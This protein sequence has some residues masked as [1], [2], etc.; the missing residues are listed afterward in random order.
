MQCLSCQ[1]EIPTKLG[2]VS[3]CHHYCSSCFSHII[4]KR[5]RKY[6]KECCPL[7]KGQRILAKDAVSRYFVKN[8]LHVPVT[9]VKKSQKKSD[10]VV[11]SATLDDV[12]VSFLESFLLGK[13]Q[14]TRKDRKN[15]LLLFSTITD[16]ELALYCQYH[17]LAFIPKKNKMKEL[18]QKLEQEHH[19]TLHS[20]SKSAQDLKGI[21]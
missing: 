20:L 6:I 15:E 5:V 21:F 19:G 11:S 7:K 17:Q 2:F 1:K 3:N 12:V 4:E 18:V 10:L 8:V 16:E 14:K 9:V 13:K